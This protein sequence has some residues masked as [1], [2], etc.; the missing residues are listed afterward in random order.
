M[1]KII[2]A[3]ILISF[4]VSLFGIMGCGPKYASQETMDELEEARQACASVK[5]EVKELEEEI[6]NLKKEKAAKEAKV[7][8]LEK[9][10]EKLEGK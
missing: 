6:E 10:L 4:I 5:A 2:T 9:Q 7:K 1:K 3:A 8:E